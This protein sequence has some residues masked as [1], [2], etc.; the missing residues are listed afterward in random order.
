MKEILTEAENAKLAEGQC[1]DCEARLLMHGPRAGLCTNILCGACRTEFNY[2]FI[3][4]ERIAQPCGPQRQAEL[5]GIENGK[6]PVASFYVS[7]I[8]TRKE[9][10]ASLG[11]AGPDNKL[12]ILGSSYHPKAPVFFAYHAE[13]YLEFRC[14]ECGRLVS[15]IAVAP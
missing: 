9:L 4:S 5:Y 8:Q 6:R 10:D 2:S 15:K 12:L 11:A 7:G 14:C 3:L 1:P 13:G